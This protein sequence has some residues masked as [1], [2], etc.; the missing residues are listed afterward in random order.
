[1]DEYYTISDITIMSFRICHASD[2]CDAPTPTQETDCGTTVQYSQLYSIQLS[3]HLCL[4]SFII[5]WNSLGSSL[6]TMQWMRWRG[7]QDTTVIRSTLTTNIH[8]M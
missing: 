7:I 2:A 1:M 8:S 6:S 4:S 3:S 5:F